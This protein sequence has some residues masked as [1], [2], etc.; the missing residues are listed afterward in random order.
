MIADK[1][2][3]DAGMTGWSF[4]LPFLHLVSFSHSGRT[5]EAAFWECTLKFK[6]LSVP[7]CIADGPVCSLCQ[8]RGV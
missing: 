5:C 4:F 1:L 3:C 8:G 7:L 6:S 2:Q